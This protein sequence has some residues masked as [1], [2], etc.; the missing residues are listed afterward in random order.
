MIFRIDIA[1]FYLLKLTNVVITNC[2]QL[3]FVVVAD[4]PSA[5]TE[6]SHTSKSLFLYEDYTRRGVII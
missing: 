5:I 6:N 3:D 1:T 2:L 4:V